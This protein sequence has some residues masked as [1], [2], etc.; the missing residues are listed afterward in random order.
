M[1]KLAYERV[2]LVYAADQ[3]DDATVIRGRH[4]E[5]ARLDA[6]ILAACIVEDEATLALAR[7]QVEHVMGDKA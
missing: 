4:A 1:A 3:T 6:G 5:Y 2:C 7:A